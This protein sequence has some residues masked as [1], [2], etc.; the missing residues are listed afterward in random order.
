MKYVCKIHVIQNVPT[1]PILL[2]LMSVVI[3]VEK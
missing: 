1:T 2:T 3:S